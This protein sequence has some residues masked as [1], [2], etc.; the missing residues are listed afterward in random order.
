M[1]IVAWI[2]RTGIGLLLIYS[3]LLKVTRPYEF[4]NSVLGYHLLGPKSATVFAG[5]LPF[6]ELS[7]GMALVCGIWALGAAAIAAL[8]FAAFSAGQA[9]ILLRGISADCGCFGTGEPVS[10]VSLLRTLA[11][12]GAAIWCAT[13]R[14]QGSPKRVGTAH[15]ALALAGS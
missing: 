8:L 14:D 15:T 9:S 7:I 4:L 5:V 2:I 1:N 12:L 11:L 3:G 13:P 6:V 10:W